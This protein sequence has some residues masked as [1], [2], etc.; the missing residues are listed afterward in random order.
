MQMRPRRIVSRLLLPGLLG[1]VPSIVAAHPGT[2]IVI[3]RLGTVY[4]VDMVSGRIC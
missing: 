1:L 3:D 4:F 2:G